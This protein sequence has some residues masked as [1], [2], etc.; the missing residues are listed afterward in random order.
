M[1]DDTPSK[2]RAQPDTLIAAPTFDYPLDPSPAA[3]KAML[4]T[5]LL[6]LIGMLD[7][8]APETNFA[9]Y[10]SSEHWYEGVGARNAEFVRKGV[11]ILKGL[12]L[13]IDAEGRSPIPRSARAAR[14]SVTI[15]ST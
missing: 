13:A 12:G 14:P 2:L 1:V 10:I 3:S 6:Q 8:L 11:D 9:H 4:D 15:P 5:F 7:E